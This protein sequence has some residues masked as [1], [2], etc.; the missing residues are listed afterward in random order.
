MAGREVQTPDGLKLEWS[1]PEILL[2]T[3]DPYIR[4]SY[5][6]SWRMTATITSRRLR[7]PSAAPT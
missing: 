1:Q 3:D 2:T 5:P 6:T 4:M 7:R